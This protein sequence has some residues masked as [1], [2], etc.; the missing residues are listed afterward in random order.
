MT[1]KE[2]NNGRTIPTVGFGTWQ[3]ADGAPAVESV[4]C[5]IETG[6]THIDGAAVY[7]NEKSVG[8]A[9]EESGKPRSDLFLT[10]KV[11]NTNRGYDTTLK[12]FETTIADLQTDYLDLYLIHWPANEL[13]FGD[14]WRDINSQTW[15]AMERLVDEGV[16]R[17]IGLSNFLPHHI[18][19]LSASANI[20]PAVNQIEFHPGV[21]QRECLDYCHDNNIVVEAWSP[22]GAGRVL[23][24]EELAAIAAK[25][26]KTVAQICLRWTVQHG[27]VTLPR[28]TNSQRIKA[29]LEIFDFEISADDM[30]RI[31]SLPEIGYSGLHPDKISF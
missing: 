4:R 20:A 25:Y 29:N 1:T 31:D 5:A 30:Q 17:T 7:A 24:N 28:S 2:L 19:A 10:S 9:I 21:M 12:S 11:W 23:Q 8:R 14:K 16:I 13:Q 3:L 6:Y 27:T 26:N 15:R 18:E 22:L